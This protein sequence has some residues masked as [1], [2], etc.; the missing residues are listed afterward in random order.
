MI[1]KFIRSHLTG[2]INRGEY[3]R[4]QFTGENLA[5]TIITNTKLSVKKCCFF[6]KKLFFLL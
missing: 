2:A 4:G 1:L 6:G 3:E 5:C